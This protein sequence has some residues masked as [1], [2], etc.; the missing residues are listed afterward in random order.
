MKIVQILIKKKVL[1]VNNEKLVDLNNIQSP[2]YH[3]D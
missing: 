3:F 2:D 1:P